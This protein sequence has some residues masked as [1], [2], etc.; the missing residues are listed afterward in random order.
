M[1]RFWGLYE[2]GDMSALDLTPYVEAPSGSVH[3]TE[4]RIVAGEEPPMT[5]RGEGFGDP[6][7]NGFP[8]SGVVHAMTLAK[9]EDI[10]LKIS[11]L[12][13]SM[14]DL[15]GLVERGDS[16]GVLDLLFS[17]DDRMQCLAQGGYLMGR[18]GDDLLRG[19]Y[20]DDR[21]SGGEGDDRLEGG[22]GQD[23]LTGGADADVFAFRSIRDSS[24]TAHADRITDLE[25]QDT[26]D[27]RGIDAKDLKD[28]NQAF[29]LVDAFDGHAG[30]LVLTYDA[31]RDVTWMEMDVDGDSQADARVR[32]EGD[33]H[34]FTGFVL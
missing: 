28:G 6:L 5:F 14:N 33:H 20:A 25:A 31:E 19:D 34:D 16:E 26:I 29:K 18:A 27:L 4:K 17:G 2:N 10:K 32:I 7:E 24:V 1:A 13:V 12:D 9:G 15:V 30:R 8:S 23:R 22:A 11:G 21:L 3:A